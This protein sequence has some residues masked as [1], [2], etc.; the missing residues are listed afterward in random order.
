MALQYAAYTFVQA[1]AAL[2]AVM[3]SSDSTLDWCDF[4]TMASAIGW[5]KL[6]EPGGYH[7]IM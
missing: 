1:P 5:R 2:D 3:S 4:L 7:C 6:F